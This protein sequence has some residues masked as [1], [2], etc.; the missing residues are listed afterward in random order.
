[1]FCRNGGQILSKWKLNKANLQILYYYF[2]MIIAKKLNKVNFRINF[3]TLFRSTPEGEYKE[4][5]QRN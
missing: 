4:S 3:L 5:C 2:S 1:M